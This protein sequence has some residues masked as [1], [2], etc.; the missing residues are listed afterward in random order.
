MSRLIALFVLFSIAV[1]SCREPYIPPTPYDGLD[2]TGIYVGFVGNINAFETR[3]VEDDEI[4]RDSATYDAFLILPPDSSK[5]VIKSAIFRTEDSSRVG[6]GLGY[7]SFLGE[8]PDTNIFFD[9]VKADTI[10]FA[11]TAN[12]VY[13]LA[14][15]DTISD[16]NTKIATIDNIWKR[17]QGAHV[18]FH[19]GD[20]VF[21]TTANGPQIGSY[22]QLTS[23]DT[24][25]TVNG[26]QTIR[27]KAKFDC[28]LYGSNGS[29]WSVTDGYYIGNFVNW[30]RD[31]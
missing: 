12:F 17:A 5:A 30:A 22:F 24:F 16:F 25:L 7:M 19:D 1:S 6:I 8:F 11:D 2:T 18:F 23:V 26:V 4:Y 31:F 13:N 20:T 14:V 29:I 27:V 9:Y 15:A 3:Y 10:K 28:T 21:Y